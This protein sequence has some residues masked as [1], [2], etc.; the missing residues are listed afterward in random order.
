M[1][2]ANTNRFRSYSRVGLAAGSALMAAVLLSGCSSVP[3]AINPVHWYDSVFSSE[4][5][6]PAPPETAGDKKVERPVAKGLSADRSNA[7]YTQDA[8]NREGTPTRP[9][10]PEVAKA[11]APK[12]A[13]GQGS[14]EVAA[15]S[16]SAPAVQTGAVVPPPPVVQTSDAAPP[17]PA[18]QAAAAPAPTL[19][20]P[21]A[22][23]E[24]VED[25]YKRRLTEFS[26]P[27][28]QP[29]AS[30]QPSSGRAPL[31]SAAP[32]VAAPAYSQSAYASMDLASSQGQVI[33]L[34]RPGHAKAASQTAARNASGA[35]PLSDFNES[36]SAASFD[37]ASLNFGEG[38]SALSDAERAHLRDVAALYRQKGG[39]LR[40]IAASSSPRLDVDPAANREANR[41]LARTRADAVASELV[42][43]GVPARKIFAGVA[44]DASQIAVADGAEILLD[45]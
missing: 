19:R 18:A 30:F 45:L 24:S 44:D 6:T 14:P 33:H 22:G 2:T 4:D 31:L 26:A 40:I 32:T 36:R 35:R 11:A 29:A 3:N 12:V 16:A 25:A 42:R 43:L 41:A 28:V 34:V 27:P 13:P 37:L 21:P 9:L 20:A 39:S 1:H 38:T 23:P 8:L 17:P 15:A 5:D 7:K 10:N